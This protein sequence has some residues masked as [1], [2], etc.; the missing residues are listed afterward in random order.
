MVDIYYKNPR[1]HIKFAKTLRK[2]MS[3]SEKILWHALRQQKE[4][5]GLKFRNQHP[6]NPFVADFACVEARLIIEID[7]ASHDSGRGQ[8]Y[9][10]WRTAIL[11]KRKWTIL[12]FSNEEILKNVEGVVTTIA[13]RAH[14]LLLI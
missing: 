11:Q 9:D 13:A 10:E 12:R 2:Q 4:Q 14:E 5:S 1:E 6:L 3:R 7:G 8:A